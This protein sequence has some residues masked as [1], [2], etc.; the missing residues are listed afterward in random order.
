MAQAHTSSHTNGKGNIHSTKVVSDHLMEELI[1]AMKDVDAF[2]SVEIMIQDYAVTQIT[3]R[4]IRKTNGFHEEETIKK[5]SY[6][7]HDA[8]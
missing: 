8:E 5:M 1:N 4:C 2:G 7:I 6:R 3:H